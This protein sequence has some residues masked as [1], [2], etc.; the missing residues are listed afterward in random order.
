MEKCWLYSIIFIL[1][2]H[3]GMGIECFHCVTA[4]NPNCGDNFMNENITSVICSPVYLIQPEREWFHVYDETTV[5]Y[6][7]LAYGSTNSHGRKSV[8]RRCTILSNIF[9]DPCVNL[10]VVNEYQN[11]TTDFCKICDEDYC[12]GNR[13]IKSES[14]IHFCNTLLIFLQCLVMFML[15]TLR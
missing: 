11:L 13:T 6:S 9:D 4:Q 14:R 15:N 8:N 5:N 3:T 2:I 12:N 10:Q 1:L 7:C